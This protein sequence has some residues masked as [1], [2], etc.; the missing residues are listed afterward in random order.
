MHKRH[1]NVSLKCPFA[2]RKNINGNKTPLKINWRI[3]KMEAPFRVLPMVPL[4]ANG[5]IGNQ[6][7]LNCFRQPMVPLVSMK[8]LVE[9][10][11]PM[12]PFV[13]PIVSMVR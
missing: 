7:T 13:G 3:S 1:G 10:L 4:V 2:N 11:V 6:R 8:Q 9:T 12:V 5:I